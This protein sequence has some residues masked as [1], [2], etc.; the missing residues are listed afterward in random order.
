MVVQAYILIQT[1][2]GK[3]ADVAREIAEIEGVTMAEDVTGPYDVIVRAEARNVDELGNS[4][5]PASKGS[6]GS[7]ARGPAQSF[8]STAV[9]LG[10]RSSSAAVSARSTSSR[11]TWCPGA[12][13]PAQSSSKRS[14]TWSP[15]RLVVTSSPPTNR[16]RGVNRRSS[17][18]AAWLPLLNTGVTLSCSTRGVGRFP[19]DGEGCTYLHRR[20]S[21][22]IC[23]GRRARRIRPEA[24]GCSR[25]SPRRY[26]GDSAVLMQ[27]RRTAQRRRQ[28]PVDQRRV[29]E[30]GRGPQHREHRGRAEPRHGVEL[31]DQHD[32]VR[33]RKKLTRASPSQ[34]SA[35]NAWADK[36]RTRS[37][38]S[39]SRIG[40]QSSATWSSSR[41]FASK[42]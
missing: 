26:V 11:T 24:G 23:R 2:V 33:T 30:A 9:A 13:G 38:T 39:A 32:A 22:T 8:R 14:P 37:A 18:A 35:W 20:G 42:S 31:V 19:V 36:V 17:S 1:E 16:P 41:Y 5:S 7:L 29:V 27:T 4:S 15:T 40:G 3:A 34:A 10:G 12:N 25:I 28:Q 21:P 6:M